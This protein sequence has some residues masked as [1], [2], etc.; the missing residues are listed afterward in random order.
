MVWTSM[1]TR[2][3]AAIISLSQRIVAKNSISPT[4]NDVGLVLRQAGEA[5]GE[6]SLYLR[7]T[8]YGDII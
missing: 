1:H 4:L 5:V 3:I 2:L 7:G 6:L 8:R